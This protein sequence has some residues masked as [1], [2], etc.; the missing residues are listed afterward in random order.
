[1]TIMEPRKH[2]DAS[3]GMIGGRQSPLRRQHE[4]HRRCDL[5]AG[6]SRQ[7]ARAC[8]CSAEH[9]PGRPRRRGR[10]VPG[11]GSTPASLVLTPEDDLGIV[12]ASDWY[13]NRPENQPHHPLPREV[14]FNGQTIVAV[15]AESR[16]EASE[17]A[18]LIDVA[19][20]G[21]AIGRKP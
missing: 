18:K 10:Y 14:R 16:E 21:D 5:C 2:G 15:V 13:G 1:M 12:A 3:D 17:A 9:D 20:R 8:R 11:A 6:I 7:R 19:L 4:G